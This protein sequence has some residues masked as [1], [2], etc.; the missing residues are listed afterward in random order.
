MVD[1]PGCHGHRGATHTHSSIPLLMLGG[2]KWG[3]L[4]ATNSRGW[5]GG[6]T[7]LE[8]GTEGQTKRKEVVP[9]KKVA[10]LG[11]SSLH[12]KDFAITDLLGWRSSCSTSQ[13]PLLA[14]EAQDSGNLLLGLYFLSLI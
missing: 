13:P 10:H 9:S 14:R 5:E 7:P 8:E 2:S 4:M 12:T 11:G 3:T 6:P 1:C